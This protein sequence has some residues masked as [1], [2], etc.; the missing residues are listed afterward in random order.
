MTGFTKLWSE[1]LTSSI[2]NEDDKTRLVWIT[3]LAA[4]GPDYIVRASVGGL[5]HQ[6]RVT[7]EDCEKALHVLRS[8]DPDS[9]SREHEGRR[10]IDID[11]GFMILNGGKY[12]EARNQDE[13]KTYMAEYMRNYRKQS[14]NKSK[15][16]VNTVNHGKPSLAQA[17]AEAE[18]EHTP[19]PPKPQAPPSLELEAQ[20]IKPTLT[21]EQIEVASWINRRPTTPWSAK[22]LKAWKQIPKPIDSEDWQA[23]KWFYTRSGC[24]YLR[25]DLC[26]LLNNWS[27]E[28]DRAKNYD[29]N[30]K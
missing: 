3:M 7:R 22:E 2:W 21:P 10:I 8:P 4:M 25:R 24:K 14:V 11:G 29:P 13:R 15:Q 5:A 19:L 18:A 27:G 6:A 17:E 20:E 9:R 28:I 12:R 1:I 16:S 23:L 26:T 30:E